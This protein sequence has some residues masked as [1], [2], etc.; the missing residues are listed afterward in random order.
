MALQ[1]RG[2]SPTFLELPLELL[3]LIWDYLAIDDAFALR[4]VCRELASRLFEPFCKEFF[5]ERRFSISYYSLNVLLEITKHPDLKKCLKHLT[6][7]LDRFDSAD[8][9]PRVVNNWNQ[10]THSATA[11]SDAKYY[12]LEA[13]NQEQNFLLNSGK[14][15]LLMSQALLALPDLQSLVLRDRNAPKKL[16][17]SGANPLLASFG[18]ERV[19]R[20]TGC[21]LTGDLPNAH[22]GAHD[23]RFVDSV[24]LA[25]LLALVQGQSKIDSLTVD[26]QKDNLGL[27]S[28]AFSLPEC[29]LADIYPILAR[30]RSLHLSVSITR[31]ALGSYS[32]RSR[33]FLRWQT[34]QL[35]SFLQKAPDLTSIR[36]QCKE[37]GHF[38]KEI[39][40]GLAD[41]LDPPE[42]LEHHLDNQLDR[43]NVCGDISSIPPILPHCFHSL[44]ELEL[45]N[46]TTSIIPLSRVLKSVAGTLRRLT[47]RKVALWVSETDAELDNDYRQPNAWSKLFQDM[48]HPLEL[49]L[50]HLELAAL[51]H[52]TKSCSD[53]NNGHPVA[54]QPSAI[55]LQSGPDNGLL[56]AWV[57]Y[58]SPNEIRKFM[59]ELHTKTMILC[60][61]CKQR[62]PGYRSVEEILEL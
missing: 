8:A 48:L 29:F 9:L 34:Y 58:G 5:T 19:S 2:I 24:F 23:D 31:S 30:L 49:E 42:T 40:R 55:G 35:A 6:I 22:L 44:K 3:L 4:L 41:I 27:S 36:I 20:E 13:L 52:H 59:E 15:Q 53:R 17:R 25:T 43:A 12:K 54:F 45:E 60:V 7:G 21:D 18:A 16:E 47:L 51:E 10:D 37:L 1:T 61:R 28:S 57:H 62:N 32:D 11:T 14:F 56:H 46:M 50:E 33:S 38:P 26:I 39:I